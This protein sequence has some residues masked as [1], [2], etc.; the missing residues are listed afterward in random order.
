MDFS[1]K[2]DKRETAGV[3]KKHGRAKRHILLSH[4]FMKS[5]SISLFIIVVIGIFSQN[6]SF[7]HIASKNTNLQMS[8]ESDTSNPSNNANTDEE[9]TVSL[10]AFAYPDN[11]DGGEVTSNTA[12]IAYPHNMGFQTKHDQ[13][14]EGTGAPD[15][16]IT[17]G[18][19]TPLTQ[20]GQA[21]FLPGTEIYVKALK[22][23]AILE[24]SCDSCGTPPDGTTYLINLWLGPSQL[25]SND[26]AQK[27]EDCVK[28]VA[29]IKTTIV[30]NPSADA[31]KY[32][33]DKTPLYSKG[34]CTAKS[35]LDKASTSGG[36]NQPPKDLVSPPQGAPT[37]DGDTIKVSVTSYG[38]PDNDDGNGH[39]KT[40]VIAFPH[41]DDYPTTKHSEATEGKGTHDDPITFAAYTGDTEGDSAAFPPGTIIYVPFLQKY[42]ILEDQ[43][44]DCNDVKG[45][46]AFH[47][48]LWLGPNKPGPQDTDKSIEDC[49]SSIT[50][51]TTIILNPTATG[52]DVDTTPLYKDGKCSAVTP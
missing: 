10:Q 11:T 7:A 24:D 17:F 29:E 38:F 44:A 31:T 43:C 30:L 46:N 1:D 12:A 32:P 3:Q 40:A 16:P 39:Y 50:R 21:V 25:T 36:E 27:I 14:T 9:V 13:A 4:T 18:A 52:H 26:E 47:I 49:E 2:R 41:S 5:L 6:T 34:D 15:D 19:F 35:L 37:T 8:N 45:D 23:F 48:D 28:Q 42:F 51:D 22:K 33:V 20:G